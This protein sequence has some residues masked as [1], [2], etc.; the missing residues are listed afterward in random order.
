MNFKIFEKFCEICNKKLQLN[1]SR[2]IER[3][4]FCS[5]SCLGLLNGLN[6]DM[7]LLHAKCNTLEA[8]A[9]KGHSK[10]S[11]PN[12]KIDRN[13][14]IS[15]SRFEMSTWR[16]AVFEKDKYICQGCFK[17]GGELQAH[18]KAP[19]AIFEK[20]RYEIFNGVT[21]CKSCHKDL[22]KAAIEFFGGLTTKENSQRIKYH[23]VCK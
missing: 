16:K 12:W 17:K 9:K 19:Y 14:I 15:R 21:L 23:A 4:R 22:H 20:L 8:N 11:H 7:A 10:E 18:H 6:R 2:D 1:N 5:K 13:S 3:K